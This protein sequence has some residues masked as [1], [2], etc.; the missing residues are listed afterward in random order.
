MVSDWVAATGELRGQ[1]A[2]TFPETLARLHAAFE[3]IHPFLDGNG[4]AD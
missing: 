3:Q 1:D 2:L 4:R